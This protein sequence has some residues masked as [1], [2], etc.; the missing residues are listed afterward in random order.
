MVVQL[1]TVG[2]AQFVMVGSEQ[3][4]VVGREQPLVVGSAV[5][6]LSVVGMVQ[7]VT[8]GRQ[9]TAVTLEQSTPRTVAINGRGASIASGYLALGCVR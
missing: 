3:P 5:Q 1:L 7:P 4:E 9:P 8:V 2:N 6:E